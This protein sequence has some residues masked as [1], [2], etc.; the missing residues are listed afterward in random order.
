MRKCPPRSIDWLRRWN[1]RS[2][3]IER[4]R[5]AFF[6][7]SRNF[8]PGLQQIHRYRT[9]KRDSSGLGPARWRAN[10]RLAR[11]F[12]AGGRGGN[13]TELFKADLDCPTHRAFPRP[14][15][16]ARPRTPGG[17]THVV[18]SKTRRLP[19]G[20]VIRIF[21]VECLPQ[22]LQFKN[23]RGALR[24]DVVAAGLGG[25]AP[26][27]LVIM[28]CTSFMLCTLS[29]HHHQIFGPHDCAPSAT[30]ARFFFNALAATAGGC[31]AAAV[32][33]FA[34]RT[35]ANISSDGPNAIALPS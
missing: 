16:L 33:P 19:R 5:P 30:G 10:T 6:V 7:Q 31:F 34:V 21:P 2:C 11:I 23:Q 9:V 14:L 20:Q 17:G 3:L 18:A 28:L 24:S 4:R 35:R 8:S 15:R 22:P 27:G 1:S 12:T 26:R 13:E 29:R 32:C 25:R